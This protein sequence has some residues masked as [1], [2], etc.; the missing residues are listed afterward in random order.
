M[1]CCQAANPLD[2]EMGGLSLV[3]SP[4]R[5]EAYA[6]LEQTHSG[7][8]VKINARNFMHH[9]KG[10]L[11]DSYALGE[12]LGDGAYGIVY[13][14]THLKSGERRALKSISKARIPVSEVQ[15]ILNEVD[16]LTSLVPSTQ[17]H[18]NILKIIEVIEDES[19]FHIVSELCTGGELFDRI[20]R[21]KSFTEEVAANYMRQ[22][23]SAVAYCHD[24]N[25]VHRDLKPE[26]LL[27]ENDSLDALLKVIDFGTSAKFH[28]GTGLHNVMGTVFARQPYYIAP[29]ILLSSQYD[30]K[31]DVWSC[32]VILYVLLCE[33]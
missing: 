31:C 6:Q 4:R 7:D 8:S 33:V 20:I 26:N 5:H 17:D 12:K 15:Q 22:L 28:R 21:Q 10:V 32:G 19:Y 18:P 3:E 2:L 29:E 23:L 14:V 16:I 24:H 27:L 9:S 11:A 30:E 1:G 25:I 13:K